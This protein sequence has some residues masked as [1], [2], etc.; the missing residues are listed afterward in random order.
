LRGLLFLAA[1]FVALSD[2]PAE[3]QLPSKAPAPVSSGSWSIAVLPDTQ[4]YA[5]SY[6]D[7]F[8]KQT[9]WLVAT[10][11]AYKT[12]LV[13][14]E[15]DIVNN[16]THPEW[17]NVRRAMDVLL[18]AAMPYVMVPG[19]HDMGDWG[20]A[21]TRRSHFSDY[22]TRRDAFG[23]KAFGTFQPGNLDNAWHSFDTPWGPF[24][25]IALEFGPRDEVVAWASE[26]VGKNPDHR[27]VLLTH[28]YLYSDGTRYDW[29]AKGE[30]QKWNPHS[31]GVA[32]QPGGVNDGEQLWQKLVSRHPNF[33]MTLNGHVLNDG[34]D[35]LCSERPNAPAVHQILANYQ[36]AVE[37]KRH[38]GGAG[39]LRLMTFQ[40]DGRTVE[41]KT[42][43]PWLNE[44]LTTPDQQFTIKL[45]A[46]GKS[47]PPNSG[48]C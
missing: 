17:L 13:L 24:L 1:S 6:P 29:A 25:I 32:K 3:A 11:D 19:N 12:M 7:V 18:R 20:M 26:I 37:P 40:P 45:D 4:N 39:F 30:A 46:W 10:R 34:A 23:S 27:A 21:N 43:S 35:Y 47:G 8:V 31:Y 14:Q 42:Y 33:V 5:L 36:E 15:G 38:F 48:K 22:F 2:A 44:S 41:I 9:E 16:N 28:A